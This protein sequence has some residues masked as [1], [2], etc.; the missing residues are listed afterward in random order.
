MSLPATR[1][2][3]LIVHGPAV[4]LECAVPALHRELGRL[5]SVFAVSEWPAGFVP[6]VGVVRPYDE[7]EVVRR[8]PATAR[9]LH[10][11][12]DLME[13]YEED[14]RFWII[15]DRW[16]MCEINVLRGQWRSWI[17]PRGKLDPVRTVEMAVLWPMAQVLR[18]KGINLLPAASVSRD[19]WGL[20]L[21]SPFGLEPELTTLLNAGF[22]VVGQ[23]W[24]AIREDD[25]RLAMLHVPGQVQR[26]G[27]PQLRALTGDAGLWIDLSQRPGSSQ[28][29]AFC[30]SVLVMSAGRRPRAHLRELTTLDATNRLRRAW[31][32]AELH[33]SG[34][35]GQLPRKLAEH[36]RCC[37]LQLSRDPRD[38]LALL[39]SLRYAPRV[40]RASAVA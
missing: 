1:P 5:L 14:E 27:S 8:L 10:K 36:C 31:P 39:N 28:H 26:Y 22:R 24:T 18:A 29:H 21:I 40:T 23:R 2:R 11:P 30:D 9:A 35:R 33:P 4:E 25:G 17:V 13:L 38:M 3:K 15:D 12:G 37:E 20:L 32:I 19:G 7:V 6:A 16:G 34:R